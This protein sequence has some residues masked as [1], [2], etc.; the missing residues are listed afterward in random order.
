MNI[1][2]KKGKVTQGQSELVLIP[3]F[4]EPPF[5][6][7]LK[8]ADKHLNGKLSEIFQSGEFKGK[9]REVHLF[10]TLGALKAK[11]ILLVG[12]GQ[13]KKLSLD[14]LREAFGKAAATIRKSGVKGFISP[15]DSGLLKKEKLRD[16]VQAMVEGSLLGLYQFNLYKTESREEEKEVDEWTLFVEDEKK[17]GEAEKGVKIGQIISEGVYLARDLGNHPSNAVTPSRLAEE[18]QKIAREFPVRVT[19]LEREDMEELKMGSFLGVSK[20][21]EEPPKFIVMEYTPLK[22]A[23]PLVL[24][25]KSITFDSGGI[26]LKPAE[27]MEQMKGDM[28]GGA[29]VLA[30]LKVAARLKLQINLI[31]ILPSTENLP[32][33]TATK[34]GDVLT[35]LSGKTIEVINT[36]AE[37]RLILADALT[38]AQRF[39]PEAIIDL[40]T[41]TGAVVVALG[42]EAIGLLGT[43][44]DL[45]EKI[46][47][48]GEKTG[49]RVWELPLWE[50]YY[51]LIK[52]DIADIKNTGGRSA[53]TITAAAFLSKFVENTPWVHLDIAAV[54]WTESDRPYIPKGNSGVGVRLLTQYLMDL[55]SR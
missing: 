20:G 46:K 17:I 28:S 44:P 22:K 40:A 23:R 13:R 26:S 43:S 31:G 39:N 4:E 11:R 29:A 48:A 25:G 14:V 38:Y 49:E 5:E 34:P 1:Q 36:D 10:H 52:S 15:V 19:V 41:L 45:K 30:I 27:K 42:S 3:V 6:G 16:V 8:T 2:V 53:G 12:L 9:P 32:S 54:A 7:A 35:S 50:G 18:A 37:G 47:K 21:S 24:V 33:G 51:D 55:E